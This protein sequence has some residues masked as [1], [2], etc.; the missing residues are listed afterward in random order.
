MLYMSP[1]LPRL[2]L[3]VL[4]L[5]ALLPVLAVPLPFSFLPRA[6]ASQDYAIEAL[7]PE[8]FQ[9]QLSKIL[10]QVTGIVEPFQIPSRSMAPTLIPGDRILTSNVPYLHGE[11]Q[12]GDIIVFRYPPEPKIFYVKRVIA[13]GGETVKARNGIIYIDGT[14]FAEPYL[15]KDVHTAD[16]GPVTVPAG[17]FFVLGDNRNLSE[18]SR[19]WGAVPRGNIIGK[20]VAIFWPSSRARRLDDKPVSM[21]RN[22]SAV[23]LIVKSVPQVLLYWEGDPGT[24]GYIVQ[25]STQ[26]GG[27]SEGQVVSESLI[28]DRMFRDMT[29]VP[30]TL[31]YYVVRNIYPD[32]SFGPPVE[33]IPAYV[34]NSTGDPLVIGL[35]TG[36]AYED[37]FWDISWTS[38]DARVAIIRPETGVIEAVGPGRANL[39]SWDDA[40]KRMQRVASVEVISPPK[41]GEGSLAPPPALLEPM[42][43]GIGG[44]YCSFSGFT[45]EVTTG[46]RQDAG[47]I[48]VRQ[49]RK[50]NAFQWDEADEVLLRVSLPDGVE[51]DTVPDRFNYRSYVSAGAS[52]VFLS[53][54]S[55]AMTVALVADAQPGGQRFSREIAVEFLFNGMAA[56]DIAPG[57]RDDVDVEIEVTGFRDSK[58]VFSE[59]RHVVIAQIVPERKP[60]ITDIT[61]RILTYPIFKDQEFIIQGRG[62]GDQGA[63]S[64]RV[65]DGEQRFGWTSSSPEYMGNPQ[66]SRI[67]YWTDNQINVVFTPSEN[68][69]VDGRLKIPAWL[70]SMP[71]KTPRTIWFQVSS[72][73]WEGPQSNAFP[74]SVQINS[75][76]LSLTQREVPVHAGV[77]IELAVGRHT[78]YV[79]REA[80]ALLAP[81]LLRNGRSFLPVRFLGESTGATVGWDPI[82]QRV[83]YR[84][85]TQEVYLWIGRTEAL[86]NGERHMLDAAPFLTGTG[87]T[88]VPVRF[89]GEALGFTV[90]WDGT[91]ETIILTGR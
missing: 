38:S 34:P 24:Q 42:H 9:S 6:Q 91:T 70:T 78:A 71:G 73:D 59:S 80:R 35:I 10:D 1:K 22:F 50:N 20:A 69:Y 4:I 25:R 74:V 36:Q 77:V 3:L 41:E 40:A 14:P 45:T 61:P 7:I 49:V 21:P 37:L 18:D 66:W 62:F 57:V 32:G 89:V 27:A 28:T 30:G 63:V 11:P 54:T 47:F 2:I 17:C 75:E 85:G 26:A 39:T 52:I 15:A 56:I 72:G 65:D 5:S 43:P 76:A 13:I 86:L 90:Q 31:Y 81:P 64:W 68:E 29:V 82:E 23:G 88:L 48:T 84:L 79:N 12:R 33:E 58:I 53:A 51:Y 67:T 44:P 46:D 8:T 83:S 16:F 87:V 19:V 55:R 60:V